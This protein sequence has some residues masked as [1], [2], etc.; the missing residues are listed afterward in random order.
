[1]KR[2]A[3]LM[4][5][6]AAGLFSVAQAQAHGPMPPAPPH[7]G[8]PFPFLEGADL[9]AK[10]KDAVK[11][12]FKEDRSSS[13]D[14]RKQDR[15]LHKQ[16]EDL[17]L[18]PGKVDQTKLSDLQKQ[19]DD[20]DA[21]QNAARLETAVKVRN[22]LTAEQLAAVKTRHDKIDALMAQIHDIEH[23]KNDN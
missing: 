16:I 19:E 1:M 2:S 15:D 23:D 20:L 12:I 5:A 21:K 14:I 4:A 13:K 22:V 10:Q 17:L 6:M 18:A 3:F 9:T 8:A 7:C 11:A